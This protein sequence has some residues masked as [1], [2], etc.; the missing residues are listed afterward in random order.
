MYTSFHILLSYASSVLIPSA[1][2]VLR[3][4]DPTSGRD[5]SD[6]GCACK[7]YCHF[8]VLFIEVCHTILSEK[9]CGKAFVMKKCSPVTIFGILLPSSSRQW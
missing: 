5:H 6:L 7:E 4:L 1:G 9:P 8:A 2:R 3:W